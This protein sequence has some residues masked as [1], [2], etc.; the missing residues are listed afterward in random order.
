LDPPQIRFN[1]LNRP[2]S[3][4]SPSFFC[5]CA[6][7]FLVH[8][9]RRRMP[10]A[11]DLGSANLVGFLLLHR[12]N[13]KRSVARVWLLARSRENCGEGG[14]HLKF[15]ASASVVSST[16]TPDGVPAFTVV[17]RPERP[18]TRPGHLPEPGIRVVIAPTITDNIYK[19]G[20]KHHHCL[21]ICLNQ[22]CMLFLPV[23]F[24]PSLVCYFHCNA[25]LGLLHGAHDH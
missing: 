12:R 10:A 20:G 14:H 24:G 1:C 25:C 11:M 21:R 13:R 23:F 17:E 8:P 4:A 15:I 6:A 9:S 5:I 19:L 7:A 3:R 22:I 2:P 16:P 18:N